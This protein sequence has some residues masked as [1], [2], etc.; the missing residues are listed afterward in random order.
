LKVAYRNTLTSETINRT[1][2]LN[3][4][5]PYTVAQG[6]KYLALQDS[7]GSYVAA[8]PI[9]T[10]IRPGDSIPWWAKF[11]APPADVKAISLYI[12]IASPF[13]DLPITDR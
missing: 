3:E 1:M 13:E 5:L 8:D 10:A 7:A 4:L 2:F 12:P 9:L 11:P 6:K